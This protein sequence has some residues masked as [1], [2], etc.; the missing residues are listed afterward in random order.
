MKR[1]ELEGKNLGELK[2]IAKSHKVKGYSKFRKS[3]IPELINLM[4]NF[5]ISK[6]PKRRSK[7]RSK[8]QKRRSKSRS[9]KPKRR[10]RSKKPKRRSRSKK[11]KRRSRSK[12][13]KRRSRSKK[14]KRSSSKLPEKYSNIVLPGYTKK[15]SK[16]KIKELKD[17]EKS[18]KLKRYSKF[19][20][21]D[22]IVFIIENLNKSVQ[23][24]KTPKKYKLPLSKDD[25][26]LLKKNE[27]IKILKDN[28]ITIGLPNKKSELILLL[29]QNKCSPVDK[30]YCDNDELCD[31]RNNVCMSPDFSKRGL[32][33]IKLDGKEIIG[34]KQAIDKLKK[35][36]KNSPLKEDNG[37]MDDIVDIVD[38][39]DEDPLDKFDEDDPIDII[40]ND[41][42]D[43]LDIFD[44]QVNLNDMDIENSLEEIEIPEKNEKT[45]MLGDVQKEVL[46]CLG[47]L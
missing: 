12:K 9:K 8:K 37:V 6:K 33:K 22:F 5:K 39:K 29:Q 40:D 4:L 26:K 41:D 44:E 14:P 36:I 17:F 43:V 18:I 25:V 46:K 27:M 32:I 42:V 11:P 38:N 30:K 16:M 23:K 21:D 1:S 20:K 15:I 34:T 31:I 19:K 45:E 35:Q 2:K 24:D 47:M 10:S 13:P 3:D 28:G 7:S